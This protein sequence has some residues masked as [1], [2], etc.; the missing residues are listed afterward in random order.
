[1]ALENLNIYVGIVNLSDSLSTI[2]NAIES[3]KKEML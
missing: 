2:I 3:Q 1:M